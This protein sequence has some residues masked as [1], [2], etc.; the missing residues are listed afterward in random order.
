MRL[1]TYYT[2]TALIFLLIAVGHGARVL[3]GWSAT[4][5]G[6]SI[7]VWV[8]VVAAIVALYLSVRGFQ[9]QSRC[10]HPNEYADS[11]TGI[12]GMR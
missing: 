10:P 4:V 11:D 12:H 5:A 2:T 6:Y 3:Y 8:S 7:P 9:L 1:R